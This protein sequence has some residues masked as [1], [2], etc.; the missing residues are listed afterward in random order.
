MRYALLVC[1]EENVVS[2]EDE[3]KMEAAFVSLQDELR[4]EGILLSA[5]QFC[6]ST[7]ATTVQVWGGD[8]VVA[9]GP[10]AETKEQVGGLLILDCQDLDH[11]TE[12]ATRIPA[13]WYGTIEVRPV[14]ETRLAARGP[15]HEEARCDTPC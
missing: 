8:V 14:W 3:A 12:I 10:F 1:G 13:A 9:G 6:P 2:P 11:A 4:S 5:E 7:T 15:A